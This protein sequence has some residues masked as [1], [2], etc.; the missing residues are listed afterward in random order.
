MKCAVEILLTSVNIAGFNM[1][2][3]SDSALIVALLVYRNTATYRAVIK[4][5]G[6][7]ALRRGLE[8]NASTDEPHQKNN[9]RVTKWQQ[10]HNLL[11]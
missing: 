3:V 10:R 6:E 9:R 2:M 8:V 5:K 7:T 11:N 4:N 1:T